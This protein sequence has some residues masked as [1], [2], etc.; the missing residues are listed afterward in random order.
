[1]VVIGRD[2]RI[3]GA[4]V[5][6]LVCHSLLMMGIDVLDCG[7]STTPSI[8]MK[9]LHSEAR[10]GIIITASHNPAQWNAL[11]FLNQEGELISAQEGEKILDIAA[12]SAFKYADVRSLGKVITD[13]KDIADHVT[14]ILKLK[15]VNPSAIATHRPHIVVDCINSTG[16]ISI[17]PLLEALGCTWSL[18]N[19]D[20][21]G[22]FVH[23]P[24]PIEEN[25]L[26]LTG[27]VIRQKADL[28][29]AVDP[30][31]DRLAFVDENGQYC[32]EEYSLVMVADWVLS[33][34]PG[35]TVSNLSSTSALK[36]ITQ[37]YGCSYSASAV[38]EVNVVEQIKATNAVIGGE[39]NGGII[40][41]ALHYG[42]DALVGIA[43]LLT[44]LSTKKQ[45][46]SAYRAGFPNF[47]IAKDKINLTV[48]TDID[49]LLQGIADDY[50]SYRI[51]KRDGVKIYFESGWIHLRKSNTEP[52]VRLY[53]EGRTVKE[54][55]SMVRSVK[56]K[57]VIE[58]PVK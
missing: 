17:P 58:N 19:E 7:L 18:I 9:V 25:L 44:A 47:V 55:Q 48:D 10:G 4:S 37:Q 49:K 15:T 2:S 32:G 53:A 56:E 12:N 42:R 11:K 29:I 3:S 52:I 57:I 31:V 27:E 13:E 41:P 40:Y 22:D 51:D 30:D 5:H 8:A 45:K 23:E 46:L 21:S 28:G 24:E 6:T 16:A 43:L 20:M 33:Q 38:G 35:N 14:A 36:I 54:S 50:K 26:Q 39:G 34:T 1:M